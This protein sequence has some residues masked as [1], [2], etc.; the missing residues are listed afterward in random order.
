VRPLAAL[1]LVAAGLT[2]CSSVGDFD[3]AYLFEEGS[4]AALRHPDLA[5]LVRTIGAQSTD[6]SHR[7]LKA[8]LQDQKLE[9]AIETGPS[10]LTE[11][12]IVN[13][14]GETF[15]LVALTP[16]GTAGTAWIR[17]ILFDASGQVL[18]H[19]QG[20]M[21]SRE[22][23]IAFAV[24]GAQEGKLA[25]LLVAPSGTRVDVLLRGKRTAFRTRSDGIKFV[26]STS[27]VVCQVGIRDRRLKL[28]G[29]DPAD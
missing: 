29:P 2:G 18:D 24:G 20:G 7:T 16:W 26:D 28:L 23:R 12:T 13:V 22:G 17:L 5:A 19:L 10:P 3:H 4:L 21:N 25:G 8:L 14:R 11:A 9:P 6:E 15:V 1:A 27:G